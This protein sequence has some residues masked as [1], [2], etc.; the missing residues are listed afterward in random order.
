VE[1]SFITTSSSS[2]V[3]LNISILLKT[4]WS[5]SRDNP[6]LIWY[7]GG[8]FN[9][10]TGRAIHDTVDSYNTVETEAKKCDFITGCCF[11]ITKNN[12]EKIG[13][14]D[15]SYFMYCE[16]TEYCLRMKKYNISIYYIPNTLLWHKVCESTG[17]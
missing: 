6:D 8:H 16:D 7:G 2:L 11:M 9:K 1:I 4:N 5:H 13:L 3:I 14:L 10:I 17:G 12:I 15:D